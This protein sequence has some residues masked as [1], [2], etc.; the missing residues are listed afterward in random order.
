MIGVA[1]ADATTAATTVENTTRSVQSKR[2]GKSRKTMKK[3]KESEA[4]P[5]ADGRK[6]EIKRTDA[7]P[8]VPKPQQSEVKHS[9]AGIGVQKP[10]QPEVKQN[11][12]AAKKPVPPPAAKNSNA[13][14]KA[15]TIKVG[16]GYESVI[17]GADVLPA[18]KK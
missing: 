17:Y 9:E 11:N 10:Q 5:L 8:N 13:V 7:P 6:L 14:R 18:P 2:C 16:D 4:F 15:P 3:K 12:V 1:T